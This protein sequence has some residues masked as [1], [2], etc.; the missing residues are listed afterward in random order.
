MRMDTVKLEC[1]LFE[2]FLGE[3]VEDLSTVLY[4]R[5]AF[6]RLGCSRPNED[7]AMFSSMLE[8]RLYG[9]SDDGLKRRIAESVHILFYHVVTG[10]G[11]RKKARTVASGLVAVYL[12]D[13]LRELWDYHESEGIDQEYDVMLSVTECMHRLRS[14]M[15]LSRPAYDTA[16]ELFAAT[17]DMASLY[18]RNGEREKTEACLLTGLD[19]PDYLYVHNE[20]EASSTLAFVAALHVKRAMYIASEMPEDSLHDYRIAFLMFR[21]AGRE[22]CTEYAEH[23]DI[24]TRELGISVF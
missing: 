20:F 15:F 1:N 7:V 17:F 4:L 11:D 14:M 23:I 5:R 2:E 3:K 19:A 13:T 9:V 18:E 6:A 22:N 10:E 21:D 16:S 12:S 8:G 24:C